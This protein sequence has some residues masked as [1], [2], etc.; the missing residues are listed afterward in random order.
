MNIKRKK[1]KKRGENLEQWT[2][3]WEGREKKM[4]KGDRLFGQKSSEG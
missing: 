2:A 1:K 4:R 3:C